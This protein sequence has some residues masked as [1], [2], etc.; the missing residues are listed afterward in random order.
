MNI[1]SVSRVKRVS[2]T[3][4]ACLFAG[5]LLLA[6]IAI[7]STAYPIKRAISNGSINQGY[8]WG[9]TYTDSNT[10]TVYEHKGIDFVAATG[11]KV[12][13]MAEG[14]VVD[15]YEDNPDGEYQTGNGWGNYVLI[16]H[17]D[18]HF[19]F[20]SGS[21][22]YV[23]TIYAHLEMDSIV[24]GE[25]TS[26]SK[27]QLIASSGDTGNSTGPHLHVQ[28]VLHPQ[29]NRELRPNNTLDSENRSR[30]PE[31]WLEPL[32]SPG[33][34]IGKVTNSSGNPISNLVI[35]G[36]GKDPLVA[37]YNYSS[38]RT[39]SYTWANPDD[40]LH[41]N[42]GTTDVKPGTYTLYADNE[43]GGCNAP[44]DYALGIHTFS[45]NRITYV[46]LYP[47]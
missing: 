18:E 36:I 22:S 24:P 28:T 45:A 14:T 34:V 8:K 3:I 32:S 47:S 1:V 11:T 42:F 13:A 2:R 26:V 23:Y 9:E 20:A 4:V 37:G 25:G 40:L 38:S 10:G 41:E 21:T 27:G 7:A 17:D 5:A 35:C 44:Y 19:D 39:Y 15:L 33:A 43:A 46:G 31:L 16:E 6:T 29:S 12:Y 30:N